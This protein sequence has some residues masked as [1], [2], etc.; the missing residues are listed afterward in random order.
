[1]TQRVEDSVSKVPEKLG[2]MLPL[3][4]IKTFIL[5]P[6]YAIGDVSGKSAHQINLLQENQ[7]ELL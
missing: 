5:H 2:V 3:C 4:R 1:M 7:L 6:E